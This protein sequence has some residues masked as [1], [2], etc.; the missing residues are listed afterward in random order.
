M[1]LE[2][3]P[4]K[5]SEPNENEVAT[6]KY[7]DT[8]HQDA[9]T[10]VE[11]LDQRHYDRI[12]DLESMPSRT[13]KSV[14]WPFVQH[15]QVNSTADVTVID[16]A[17]GDFF[18][19]YDPQYDLKK[20]ALRPQMDSSASWW[21]QVFGHADPAL[22]M[23]AARAAGR[24]GHV[25]FP[26]ATHQPALELAERMLKDGPGKDWASRV[27]FSDNGSTGMEIALKMA[28]RTYM[29]SRYRDLSPK[30]RQRIGVLGLQGSYHGDTI[31]AMD[32]CDAGDGVYTCEW[33]DS[34]GYWLQC[35]TVSII[36]GRPIIS[37]HGRIANNFGH[38]Q[39]H[40][41]YEVEAESFGWIYDIEE[42]L[43]TPL[44]YEY[45][46]F[47]QRILRKIRDQKLATLGALVMEPLVMGAGGMIFV[48]PLYQR[49][50]VDVVRGARDP[51][52]RPYEGWKNI[53]VIFD[54][55]FVGL[56][57]LGLKTCSSI[58][59][60]TPDIA[61]YAKALTGGVVPM[62]LTLTTDT[63]FRAFYSDRK[64]EALLHGHSYTAHAVGCEVANESLR[65]MDKIT[66]S[67][68]WSERKT[69]WNG[70]FPRLP[71]EDQ[72]LLT[73]PSPPAIDT[74]VAYP[75]FSFWDPDFIN[76]VS[77]LD[78][79]ES[80]MTLGTVLAVQLAD[81]RSGKCSIFSSPECN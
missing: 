75:V 32:A 77:K 24:Y 47:I 65:I 28:L 56:N 11:V 46:T 27:F 70:V 8:I 15:G 2:P 37:I 10:A 79:V 38:T 52:L 60:V 3:P 67:E 22:A 39:L 54:E 1:A 25:M 69:R 30:E 16:S 57:R 36:N 21:T 18:S 64:S 26:K 7:Y 62:A 23:A 29:E 81:R 20:S 71:L 9:V 45:R 72:Y 80:V 59:G 14:W 31:G 66:A 6:G 63:I 78:V 43:K 40:T 76:A 19:I 33:H 73:R 17:K 55:V 4:P 13:M 34:K 35:P 41:G 58:L 68:E 50:L 61:V 49:L 5:L 48:D 12:Y 44:A 74:A 53:P 42:R 51:L